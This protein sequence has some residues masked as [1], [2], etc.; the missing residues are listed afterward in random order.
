M[1]KPISEHTEKKNQL[2]ELIQKL[3]TSA[4]KNPA[5]QAYLEGFINGY[6]NGAEILQEFSPKPI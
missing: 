6:C 4:K 2:I 5:E 3:R 1:K